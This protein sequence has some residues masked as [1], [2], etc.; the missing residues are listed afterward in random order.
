MK[1]R[2]G[3][4]DYAVMAMDPDTHD[5]F[6]TNAGEC[7]NATMVILVDPTLPPS[8]QGRTLLHEALHA[9]WDVYGLPATVTQEGAC[10]RLEGPLLCLIRDNP[11]MVAAIVG[12]TEGKKLKLPVFMEDAD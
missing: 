3:H 12:C 11:H 10:S 2:V 4:A 5:D 8:E 1:L 6:G 9:V 7:C